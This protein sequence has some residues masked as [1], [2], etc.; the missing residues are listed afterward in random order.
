MESEKV[1]VV[2]AFFVRIKRFVWYS[3]KHNDYVSL[4]LFVRL[5]SPFVAFITYALS[6]KSQKVCREFFAIYCFV[7]C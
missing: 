1:V 6:K 3:L 7:P 4:S 5:W 2:G